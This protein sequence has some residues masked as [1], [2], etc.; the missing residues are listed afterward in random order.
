[1]NNVK[2]NH[3]GKAPL[4]LENLYNQTLSAISMAADDREKVRLIANFFLFYTG[5]AR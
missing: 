3:S 2:D 1:M 5:S 4:D